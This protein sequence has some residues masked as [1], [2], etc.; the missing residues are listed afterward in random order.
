M[1]PIPIVPTLGQ[2]AVVA[3]GEV[4]GRLMKEMLR[5]IGKVTQAQR[6]M[7]L[8]EAMALLGKLSGRG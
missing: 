8:A 7:D 4:E 2:V 3:Q 6:G 5:I 1:P